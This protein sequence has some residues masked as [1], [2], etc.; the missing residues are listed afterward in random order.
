MNYY[1][2]SA[3]KKEDRALFR[4]SSSHLNLSAFGQ[5]GE[6]RWG[7]NDSKYLKVALWPNRE[8][9]VLDLIKLHDS[10]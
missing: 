4:E 3:I 1:I 10:K 8:V 5:G 2:K 9:A 6:R 7:I